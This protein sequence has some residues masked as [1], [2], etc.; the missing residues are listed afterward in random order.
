MCIICWQFNNLDNNQALTIKHTSKYKYNKYPVAHILPYHKFPTAILT[1]N[2]IILD[3]TY[4][5]NNYEFHLILNSLGRNT[6]KQLLIRQNKNRLTDTTWWCNRT[7]QNTMYR[8]CIKTN[9]SIWLWN[10]HNKLWKYSAE[11]R[12]CI[13]KHGLMADNWSNKINF[14]NK[15]L[16]KLSQPMFNWKLTKK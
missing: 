3:Q 8:S 13:T 11:N 2:N 1:L 5:I 15:Q 10:S 7:M 12:I 14:Y 4:F 9:S 6:F 16:C